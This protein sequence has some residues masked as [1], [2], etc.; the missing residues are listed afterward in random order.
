MA[1]VT[2]PVIG[3][4]DQRWLWAGGALVVG[5]V[6]YAW[7]TRDRGGVEEVELQPEPGGGAAPAPTPGGTVDETGG[8]P[9][10]N[11]EWTDAAVQALS[12]VGFEPGFVATALGAYLARQRLDPE[13]VEVVRTAKA[14]V[15]E[16]PVGEW[17]I[18]EDPEPE[19]DPEPSGAPDTP[20]GLRSTNV[21]YDRIV[22][23]W[24]PVAGA[25][26]YRI[27]PAPGRAHDV[28]STSEQFTGLSDDK[29]YRFR[30]RAMGPG[31]M[32]SWSS[33]ISV[34]TDKRKSKSKKISGKI[35]K[36][37]KKKKKYVTVA[38]FTTRNPPW[39]S[40]LSGI[41][42]RKGTTVAKLM[43]LNPSIKN[44]DLIYPGQRIRYQ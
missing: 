23:V 21:D 22:V 34:R 5:I 17:P 1:E 26:R 27:D 24:R 32:S 25:T 37:S 16:P 10:T 36:K 9:A 28:S 7:Y 29:R 38:R 13:Q 42:A 41:A 20:G 11:Q 3:E 8:A 33:W 19:P 18:L 6:G 30:V 14:L 15:G 39:N 12:A 35:V 44:R 40:T 31:G 43:Q 4:V 2:L